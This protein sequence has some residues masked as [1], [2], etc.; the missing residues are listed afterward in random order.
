MPV[1]PPHR[2]SHPTTLSSLEREWSP[3]LG[4]GHSWWFGAE[5]V[6]PD[7]A[8]HQTRQIGELHLRP[9][10]RRQGSATSLTD[11]LNIAQHHFHLLFASFRKWKTGV[12]GTEDP[13]RIRLQRVV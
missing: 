3:H 12:N 7:F 9:E 1:S 13:G 8:R 11:T 5:V 10:H 6:F 4:R 2:L